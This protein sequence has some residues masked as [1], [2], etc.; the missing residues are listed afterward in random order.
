MEE[1]E[2][3]KKSFLSIRSKS[4]S[5]IP[6]Q[7]SDDS[8]FQT[9]FSKSKSEGDVYG[10]SKSPTSSARNS[11]ISLKSSGSE[12]HG[13][14]TSLIH[15]DSDQLCQEFDY[16]LSKVDESKS[17]SVDRR[18]IELIHQAL[19]AIRTV[20][21]R[22]EE[23]KKELSEALA[24]I[25]EQSNRES[26]LESKINFNNSNHHVASYIVIHDLNIS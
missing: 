7:K 10:N 5:K 26:I 24:K 15:V 11:T 25:E 14:R 16:F 6:S 12:S 20:S 8:N 13:S 21:A 1:K 2:T 19:L 23:S 4:K 17:T 9:I 22:E 18:A 3:K